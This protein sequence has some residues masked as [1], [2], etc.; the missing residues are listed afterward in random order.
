MSEMA[1]NVPTTRLVVDLDAIARNWLYLK[2]KLQNGADC[3]GVVKAD[4]YGLGAEIVARELFVQGCRHFFVAKWDEGVAVQK[5]L[6]DLAK[7][8]PYSPVSDDPVV[9]DAPTIYVLE[10]PRG[11]DRPDF[12]AS[13]LVPVL[14]SLPDIFYWSDA[15]ATAGRRLPAIIHIDTGM[16]RLG[17]GAAEVATLAAGH[18]DIFKALDIRYVMSHLA[19]ADEPQHPLNTEQLVNFHKLTAALGQPLRYSFANSGGIFLGP[20]YHFDLARPGCAIYGINPTGQ[21]ENPMLP[22]VT[23]EAR[24]LQTRIID[25]PATVGYGASYRVAPP[26][27]CA[28]VSIGYA[29]GYLRSLTGKG[30][31]Y[32]QG[33]KCPVIGRVSMDSIVIDVTRIKAEIAPGDAVEI[34]GAQR[35][36]DDA[37]AEAGTI[38]YEILTG[39]GRRTP[40][41]YIGGHTA[42]E[43]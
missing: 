27:K 6:A 40:R 32:V 5:A 33:E 29:D 39:L 17:L 12:I 7:A 38:G 22:V 25:S 28:T 10:G 4:A 30:H 35:L 42:S 26:A 41:Q 34:L 37:A 8:F 19:C 20:D 15:A 36:V 24:I 11:A 31:V 18:R 16:H 3:A 2:K 14:N 21:P 13:G 23:F 43:G 1:F 9:V